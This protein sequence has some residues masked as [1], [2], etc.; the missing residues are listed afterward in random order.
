MTDLP[1]DINKM[2]TLGIAATE[3]GEYDNALRVLSAVYTSVP[4]EKMPQGLSSY[5]LC[6]ARV[7]GKRKLGAELCEKAIK[8][9]SYEG[10]HR[11]NLVRVYITAKNRKKAVD[12]LDDSLRRLR[13]DPELMR[14][15][16]EIGYR[17]S[18][19]IGFLPRT[20]PISKLYSRYVPKLRRRGKI[21]L[22]ALVS[23]LYAGAIVGIFKLIVK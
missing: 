6:L 14:V 11:A 1:L 3:R 4:A 8:L 19:Q 17:Q 22:I 7:E 18:P 21:I 13:N 16:Q 9:Q 15:R 12:V 2:L 20:N 10:R 5:G 23:L